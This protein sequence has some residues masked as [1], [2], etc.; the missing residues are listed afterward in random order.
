VRLAGGLRTYDDGATLV[1]QDGRQ[2]LG[3][4]FGVLVHQHHQ[5][6]VGVRFGQIVGLDLDG[7]VS[8]PR[9]E[10]ADT[11]LDEGAQCLDD[12]CRRPLVGG[13]QVEDQALRGIVAQQ[14]RER[15]LDAIDSL[16]A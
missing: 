14:G 3:V 2:L 12:D 11:A 5:R 1:L 9:V 7:L 6:D 16:L 15:L 13:T 4:G 10:L 8:Q